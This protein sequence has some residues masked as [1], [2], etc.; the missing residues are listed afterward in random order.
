[1]LGLGDEGGLQGKLAIPI[2][3]ERRTEAKALL[4]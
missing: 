3:E 4:S 1:M 2:V